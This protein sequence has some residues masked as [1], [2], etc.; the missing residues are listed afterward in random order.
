VSGYDAYA[1]PPDTIPS[2]SGNDAHGTACA[3]IIG[4]A[5]DNS[6]GVAGM[7]WNCSIMP[8]RIGAG[9]GIVPSAAASGINWARANG[10]D[11]IS[12]S[13][14]GPTGDQDIEEAID[15][16]T[17]YGRAGKGCVVVCSSGNSAQQGY[18]VLF[19]AWLPNVIAVGAT[20]QSDT[21][22]NYSCGG[23]TLD[24]VAPSG[25]TGWQGDIW[26]TDLTG[27]SGVSSGDYMSVFGGTSAAC[28]L[29]AGLAGL[30]LSKDDNLTYGQV[31]TIIEH[32]A[33][34]LSPSGWDDQTGWGRI[35]A[36]AALRIT[37][38]G[39]L[40]GNEVWRG[41]VNIIGNVTIPSGVTLLVIDGTTV[42]VTGNYKIRVEGRL[43]TTGSCTFTRSGGQWYG[44]EFYNGNSGSSL[45]YATIQNAQYGVYVYNTETSISHCTIRY[46]TN[47]V[48]AASYYGSINWSLIHDNSYGVRCGTYGDPDLS[49]NNILRY[50]GRGVYAEASGVPNLGS[51][52]GYNSL[53]YNDYY[54]VESQYAGTIYARGN[55]WGSYPADP[56]I[57]GNVDYSSALSVDPNGWA[58]AVVKPQPIGT[59]PE[60]VSARVT[61]GDT[62][63]I[64]ELNEAYALLRDNKNQ[65]TYLSFINLAAKYPD[66]FVGS[67]ALA[68]AVRL[69]DNLG[70]DG[71]RLLE[72][73]I[74]TNTGK[75]LAGTA[76]LLLVGYLL[77][78][79]A[80]KQALDVSA[81]LVDFPNDD[82]LK[83]GLYNAGNIAWYRLDDKTV[84]EEYFR[85]LIARYPTDPLAESAMA[86]LGEEPPPPPGSEKLSDVP[87]DEFGLDNC[88]PNPFNPS[89]QVSFV[90]KE[91][92]RVSLVV[93]DIL[94]REVTTLASGFHPAGRSVATWNG[95]DKSGRA[96]GSGVYFARLIVTSEAGQRIFNKATKLLLAK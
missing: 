2:P 83:H 44:I 25:N 33:K 43:L 24:V 95:A 28:P 57:S 64:A 69:A 47:G 84:G 20:N 4:A 8:I 56:S 37:R 52:I 67:R 76:K 9:G 80:N 13:W 21:K 19:P 51:Y 58:K 27:S 96:V 10:A 48:F 82:I 3:G 86:T 39:T 65:T 71:R 12:N 32:T 77:R 62:I 54:D 81:S 63:G 41:N 66:G 38:I 36:N 93:F 46:N 6:K 30:I 5:T 14:S 59:S 11:I 61:A 70:L 18:T 29:V 94:G 75:R 78:D 42:S 79:G 60:T 49:P 68:T 87:M 73:A 72:T 55:W 31:K 26:T 17:T 22:W 7:G 50:N 74:V 34:D 53:Y 88:Y 90:L 45:S 23:S 89:T 92:A 15:Y 1:N 40:P 85:H 16:A 35:D 91:P